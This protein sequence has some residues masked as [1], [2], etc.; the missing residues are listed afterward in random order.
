[1][2]FISGIASAQVINCPPNFN[3]NEGNFNNWECRTGTVG[4]SS[5]GV[6]FF[7]WSANAPGETRHTII[8]A[9]D[10]G[11]DDYGDFPIKCPNGSPYTVRLG[12][13]QTGSESESMSYTL[14][15]PAGSTNFSVIYYYA[16][17]FEDPGHELIEQPRFF[18]NVTDASTGATLPCVSFD[19]TA[20]AGLPGFR[21]STYKAGV[22]YKDWTPVSIDLSEYAGRT[23]KL[24]F[25]TMDCLRLGHFGY[26][27]VALDPTCSGSIGGNIL[28][29]DEQA[30]TLSAP[31]GFASYTWFSDPSFSTVI[32]TNQMLHL[33]NPAGGSIIPL[34]VVPY[35]GFGCED[36]LYAPITSS[37]IP[38]SV[39]GMDRDACRNE[40]VQLGGPPVNG[41]SYDWLPASRVSDP[42]SSAPMGFS[43]RMG[44]AEFVVKTTDMSSGC[45][46]YDT[47]V[48]NIRPVNILAQSTGAL[49]YCEGETI[50]TVFRTGNDVTDIQWHRDDVPLTGATD[51]D[52]SPTATGVYYAVV[53]Q[54]SCRD[55]TNR[56]NFVVHPKPVAVFNTSE[57][58]YCSRVPVSFTNNS[59]YAG[60]TAPGFQWQFSDGTTSTE[61]SIEKTFNTPGVVDVKLVASGVF[62]CRD[63]I[64]RQILIK[65][66]AIPDFTWD[67]V[68]ENLP[69]NFVN[70][71]N[72]QGAVTTYQWNFDNGVTSNSETP[73]P[74]TFS[75]PGSFNVLLTA[76]SEGCENAPDRVTKIIQVDDLPDPVSYPKV[77]TTL[78]ETTRLH[79]RT[80]GNQFLWEPASLVDNPAI[81]Q[82]VFTGTDPAIFTI[83]ITTPDGCIVV[84]TVEVIV[85]KEDGVWMPTAF[86]PNG[87]GLNDFVRPFVVGNNTLTQFSIFNRQGNRVFTSTSQSVSWNGQHKGS[88]LPPDVYVWYIEYRNEAGETKVKKGLL[89]LV[90]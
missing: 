19:F 87:D 15:I 2:I 17:V 16:V 14:S 3:F 67:R 61:F 46:S 44:F 38:V 73:V 60:T 42:A 76:T 70:N 35:P 75:D 18:V 27:Y 47:V 90:R 11:R 12:N 48:I 66:R 33:S 52:Y 31:F 68:C 10:A 62:G 9:A 23:I 84:D 22:L 26:A 50:T 83:N 7:N 41:Y 13:D 53:S 40:A 63:S 69:V 79:A 58:E 55:T 20:V 37:P 71:S 85:V 28:C 65:P 39:A 72:T 86:S 77:Y 34:R 81:R 80:I 5:P 89:T 88:V 51:R 30:V 49:E 43:N 6:L 64:T 25:L 74:V 32:G 78:Q 56:F 21:E 82:P 29:G 36:T 59:T 8:P 24:E 57:N 54:N 4:Q 1:M 45:F